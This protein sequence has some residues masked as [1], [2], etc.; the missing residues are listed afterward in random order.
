MIDPVVSLKAHHYLRSRP[1]DINPSKINFLSLWFTL[2]NQLLFYKWYMNP[3]PLL[4]IMSNS[5]Y[6]ESFNSISSYFIIT[7]EIIQCSTLWSWRNFPYLPYK[8]SLGYHLNLSDLWPVSFHDN[9]Q[10]PWFFFE[11]MAMM[12]KEKFI[13]IWF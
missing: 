4:L 7:R 9:E 3:P 12:I 5:L 11:S 8:T 2:W 1:T 13:S 10:L 6:W